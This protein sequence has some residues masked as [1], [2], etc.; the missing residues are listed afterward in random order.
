PAFN[1]SHDQTLQLKSF[2]SFDS[3]M[4]SEF[5]LI[6]FDIELTVPKQLINKLLLLVT[7]FSIETLIYLPRYLLNKERSRLAVRTQSVRVPTQMI[8]LYC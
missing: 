1:L 8:A 5:I 3:S 6:S 7:Q 2:M 4:N